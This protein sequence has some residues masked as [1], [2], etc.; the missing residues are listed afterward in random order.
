MIE[1]TAHELHQKRQ[2]VYKAALQGPVKITH[3]FHGEFILM[4]ADERYC[5]LG[6]KGLEFPADIDRSKGGVI[7]RNESYI[8]GEKGLEFDGAN[9]V[10]VDEELENFTAGLPSYCK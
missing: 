8:V 5:L 7:K 1:F 4:R 3:K 6:D 9:M 10:E 2:E